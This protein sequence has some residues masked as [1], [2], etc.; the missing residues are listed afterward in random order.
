MT[1][2]IPVNDNSPTVFKADVKTWEPQ[3]AAVAPKWFTPERI[4]TLALQA[5]V[6]Q[7]ELQQVTKASLYL[8]LIKVARWALD[9][10]DGVH[11]V[12]LRQKFTDSDGR[13]GTRLIVEAWP[14]YKG[15]KALAIR[16]GIVRS[17]DEYC[18]WKGDEFDYGLG[19]DAYLRHKPCAAAR[20]GELLGAYTI[21]TKPR[22][23]RTFHYMPIEDVEQI[24]KSSRSWGPRKYPKCPPWYAMKSVVRNYLN[25]QPKTGVMASALEAD[26]SL[27]LMVDR[28]TGEILTPASPTQAIEPAPAT[29]DT[30][31]SMDED[32]ALDRAI[33]TREG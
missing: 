17:M 3:L 20:R 10:G 7:P 12:P 6:H 18:V 21:I 32:L 30:A 33:A 27:E 5:A 13:E 19:L 24:R 2:L 1:A 14:D 31:E 29:Q 26:E 15:L 22:G 25:R 4:T 28:S 9:I 8:A 23:V 11:L 16:E